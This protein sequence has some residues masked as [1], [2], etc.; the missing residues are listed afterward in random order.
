MISPTDLQTLR[1][2]S[3]D[4]GAYETLVRIFSEMARGGAGGALSLARLLDQSTDVFVAYGPGPRYVGIN[5]LGASL[6]GKTVDEVVGKT[7]TELMGPGAVAVDPYVEQCFVTGAKVFVLHEIPTSGGPRYFDTVY[8]PVLGEGGVA[9]VI[10]ICRDVT[11][12]RLRWSRAQATL[13]TQE[14]SLKEL[15]TPLLHVH[16]GIVF[17]PLIGSMDDQ[18]ASQMVEVL[19][20]GVSEFRAR[21]AI[22]DITGVPNMNERV[23]AALITG[24][25]AVRLLGARVILT[26]M[27][28]RV[29]QLLVALSIDLSGVATYGSLE[30]GFADAFA[31]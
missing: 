18:R 10:G 1:E 24:A 4:E 12:D 14:Q 28:P 11:D 15:S 31:L 22:L 7:N 26:G 5:H 2:C 9:Q 30:Q 17:V 20:Q 8:S 21:V 13:E 19:L 23:A 16:T 25:S 6:L 3:R 29:A 27:S